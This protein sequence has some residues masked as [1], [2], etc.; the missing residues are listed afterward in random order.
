MVYSIPIWAMSIKLLPSEIL[1]NES[2]SLN[3]HIII[4][5]SIMIAE[6][7]G[8]K[9]ELEPG[10]IIKDLNQKVNSPYLNHTHLWYL[11]QPR[12]LR[13][14]RQIEKNV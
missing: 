6:G 11:L 13:Y 7:I 9:D 14:C 5:L 3:D 4:D 12:K 2:S 8:Y 10:I 1:N